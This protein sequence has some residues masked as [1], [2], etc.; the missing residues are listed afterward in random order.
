[1]P[2]LRPDGVVSSNTRPCLSRNLRS[3]CFDRVHSSRASSRARVRSRAASH[4][5]SGT[6]T[7]TTLPTASVLARNSASFRS[8]L[9][10]RSAGGLIIL[11]TAPT[12]QSIPRA[13]SFFC[14][15]KPVGPD[16]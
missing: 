1:M 14:R 15:S 11:E 9:R 10:P 13:A 2:F 5:P 4:S 12:T 16:S 6:Q 7:S 8:F 3:I